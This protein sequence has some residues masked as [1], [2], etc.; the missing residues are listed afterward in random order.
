LNL[1]GLLFLTFA[2]ITF[3]FPSV[4]PV[5]SQNMNYCSAAIGVIGLV[6]VVTWFVDG[7]KNFTGPDAG[8]VLNATEAEDRGLGAGCEERGKLKE[9]R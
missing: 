7:R 5:N 1:I 3:N 2:A 9:R 8:G 4:A 6:S